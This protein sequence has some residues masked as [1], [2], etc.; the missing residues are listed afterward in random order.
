M[1]SLTNLKVNL[2]RLIWKSSLIK[3]FRP[4]VALEIGVFST[5]QTRA[6]IEQRARNHASSRLCCMGVRWMLPLCQVNTMGGLLWLMRMISFRSTP[7]LLKTSIFNAGTTVAIGYMMP[8]LVD[9]MCMPQILQFNP[10]PSWEWLNA[11][12]IIKSQFSWSKLRHMTSMHLPKLYHSQLR[13]KSRLATSS[14][15]DE[16]ICYI[17]IINMKL[18]LYQIF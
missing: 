13:R 2:S 7:R 10:L 9:Q 18:N 8:K 4:R 1:I 17:L 3:K 6:S 11:S 15:F 12:A 14:F 5:I 16:L